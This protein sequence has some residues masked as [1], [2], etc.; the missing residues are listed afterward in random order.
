M[1][2]FLLFCLVFFGV[3]IKAVDGQNQTRNPELQEYRFAEGWRLNGLSG[4]TL[5]LSGFVQPSLT[6]TL[7]SGDTLEAWTHRYRMRRIRLRLDGKGADPRFGYR[8]QADLSGTGEELDG[9]SNYLLDAYVTWDPSP[10]WSVTLGQRAPY[11]DNRELW[12]QCHA[13]G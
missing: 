3:R 2:R 8:I 11:T 4:S 7:Q 10:K 5:R 13:F 1:L 9:N 6:S 12:M